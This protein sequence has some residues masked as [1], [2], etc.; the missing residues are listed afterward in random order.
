MHDAAHDA[1][2]DA[3]HDAA[4]DAPS[5]AWCCNFCAIS[6]RMVMLGGLPWFAKPRSALHSR[7]FWDEVHCPRHLASQR[8]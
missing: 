7:M 2:H 4:R 6:V 5:C 1:V 8:G 3:A